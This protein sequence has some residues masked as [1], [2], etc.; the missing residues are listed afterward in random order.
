MVLMRAC[1]KHPTIGSL[2]KD[3]SEVRRSG[4]ASLRNPLEAQV[5]PRLRTG[6]EDLGSHALWKT[7]SL[8]WKITMFHR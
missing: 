1:F 5:V 8:P 4:S 2:D 6:V 7:N 3:V